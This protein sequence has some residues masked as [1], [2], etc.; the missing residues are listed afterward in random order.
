MNLHDGYKWLV[1]ASLLVICQLVYSHEMTPTYPK[2]ES[3]F[4]S[5]VSK[6]TMEMFNKREDVEYY[7]IG[8]FDKD[9]KSIPFVSK[10][11]ILKLKYLGHVKFD[12]YINN[13]DKKRA[14][15]ICSK[16]KIRKEEV[17]RTSIASRICSKFKD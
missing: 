3:T 16:S 15:Y 5:G 11:E 10:Y 9:F 2:W 12:V 13:G 4:I 7:E 1:F 17:T 8:V 6:T 14:V